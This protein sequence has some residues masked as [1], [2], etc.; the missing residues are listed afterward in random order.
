MAKGIRGRDF[1]PGVSRR[2]FDPRYKIDILKEIGEPDDF[3]GTAPTGGR[4]TE[5]VQTLY[6]HRRVRGGGE[7]GT[8]ENP[9]FA[10]TVEYITS[11]RVKFSIPPPPVDDDPLGFDE[12]GTQALGD[13]PRSGEAFRI[14][15][16]QVIPGNFVQEADGARFEVTSVSELPDK[17]V[18]IVCNAENA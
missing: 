6:A 5:R 1:R 10:K 14:E 15:G 9:T 17:R 8:G 7:A 4:F 2:R 3:A 13:A 11:P 18:M 12:L 16:P